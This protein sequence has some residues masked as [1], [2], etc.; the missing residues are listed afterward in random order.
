MEHLTGEMWRRQRA[1]QVTHS[2]PTLNDP[3]GAPARDNPRLVALAKQASAIWAKSY[4]A[5]TAMTEQA[6]L[7][8]TLWQC[9]FLP[10]FGAQLSVF[11]CF[12]SVL[13]KN[14]F[15]CFPFYF[16]FQFYFYLYFGELF[17]SFSLTFFEN[18]EQFSNLCLFPIREF[19][20]L[21]QF[22]INFQG[23]LNFFPICVSFQI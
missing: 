23:F 6:G 12:L 15:F 10:V 16:P 17:F 5:H 19:V 18:Q 20:S 14:V 3:R 9:G 4:E 11:I 21:F 22:V 2:Q 8:C 1:R 13:T 7:F